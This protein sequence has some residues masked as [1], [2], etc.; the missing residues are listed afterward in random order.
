MVQDDEAYHRCLDFVRKTGSKKAIHLTMKIH[1]LTDQKNMA[2][3]DSDME[4]S[5]RISNQMIGCIS[6]LVD[7]LNNLS[8]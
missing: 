7:T 3:K 1:A 5:V 6:E 2:L 8:D 4:T